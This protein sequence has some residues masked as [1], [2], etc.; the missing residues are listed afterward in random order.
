[1]PAPRRP[2]EYRPYRVAMY[3]MFL[4]FTLVFIWLVIWSVWSDLYLNDPVKG[5]RAERPTVAVCVDEL[6]VLFRKLAARS[7][8]AVA[9]NGEKDWNDFTAEFENRFAAF[10]ARCV[11]G[12]VDGASAEEQRRI[13]DAAVRLDALRL[14]LSR[15][16]E[17]GDRERAG[18]IAA[19]ALLRRDVH[20]SGH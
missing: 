14:H 19:I 1:M 12:P 9:P 7:S 5:V 2:L 10:E 13:A 15:C 16:G 20:E 4:A 3:A 17:E 8:A 6:E 11:D 18:V